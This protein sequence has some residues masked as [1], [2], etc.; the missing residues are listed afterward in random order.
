MSN[1]AEIIEF[2]RREFPQGTCSVE[3]VANGTAVDR[4]IIG[5]SRLI[6]VGRVLAIGTYSIPPKRPG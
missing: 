2:L 5:A 3:E 1:K 4:S 6:K